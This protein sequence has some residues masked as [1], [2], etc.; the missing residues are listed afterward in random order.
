MSLRWTCQ[1]YWR[2]GNR[3]RVCFVLG[4]LSCVLESL[5]SVCVVL[6]SSS[7]VDGDVNRGANLVDVGE[8]VDDGGCVASGGRLLSWKLVVVFSHSPSMSVLTAERWNIGSQW[9]FSALAMSV[10]VVA[11]SSFSVRIA[12]ML[13]V[14]PGTKRASFVISCC[15]RW[16]P[17]LWLSSLLLSWSSS[18]VSC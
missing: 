9:S 4:K 14:A 16:V 2:V 5:W 7:E 13:L 1:S 15:R 8:D 18:S 6:S 3:G 17:E 12:P 11:S 10:G